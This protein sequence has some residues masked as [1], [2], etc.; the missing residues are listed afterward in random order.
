MIYSY[1]Y[2]SQNG[3]PVVNDNPEVD[4]TGGSMAPA[5]PYLRL[6]TGCQ[7]VL[8]ADT[9]STSLPGPIWNSSLISMVFGT[10][11]RLNLK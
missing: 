8:N 2:I 5:V 11:Q 10:L 3:I 9:C 1:H 4:A 6:T 7:L